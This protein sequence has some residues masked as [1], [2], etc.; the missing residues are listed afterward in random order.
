MIK[1]TFTSLTKKERRGFLIACA[2]FAISGA[3]AAIFAMNRNSA[4]VPVMGGL[5]REGI[6]G[7]PVAINP[8]TS[9]NPVD[10]DIS[11]VVFGKVG[12]IMTNLE[13]SADGKVYTVKIQEDIKWSNKRPLTSDDIVFTVRTIQD[14]ETR[15]PLYKKWSGVVVERISE[16]Q[17]RFTL[18]GAY[19]FFPETARTLPIIPKEIFGK[20][21]PANLKLSDYNLAPVGSGPYKIKRIAKQKNGF[22]K[23][24]RLIRNDHYPKEPAFIDEIVFVFFENEEDRLNAFKKRQIDGLGSGD[25]ESLLNKKNLRGIKTTTVPFA[26]VYAIFI[27]E[28]MNPELKKKSVREALR[29]AIRKENLP[30]TPLEGPI[31]SAAQT[32]PEEKI[33]EEDMRTRLNGLTL[34]LVVPDVS[35]LKTTA[36]IVKEAWEAAGAE[37]VNLI[38]LSQDDILENV[39]K[40]ANY[41]M[42]LF[43]T[44]ADIP[45]DTLPFWHSSERF[46]PGLNL[47]L[48][49]NS[50]ADDAMERVRKTED[51]TERG[52]LV[53]KTNDMIKNDIPAIFLYTIPYEHFHV[54]KLRIVPPEKAWISSPS[55]RFE[56]IAKWYVKQ[57]RIIKQKEEVT[58]RT[59]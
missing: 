23:E 49:K 35:F 15:S 7:Q 50:R 1:K 45:E 12:D 53:Q 30:G 4:F 31:V 17:V 22:I 41:E 10:L 29:D 2:V 21:P 11:E 48:Y 24:I 59:P 43:G 33:S 16:L 27:N 57:A 34:N 5:Y 32:A 44:I 6:V 13:T 37:S 58:S 25:P 39:L 40:P 20:I 47:S 28:G 8:I 42:L 26:R 56:N 46:Y 18:P 19:V 38:V 9:S 36:E 52:G 14:P 55:D 51:A 3:G 54:K